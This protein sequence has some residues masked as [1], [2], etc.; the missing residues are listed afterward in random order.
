LRQ[1]WEPEELVECWTLL[2]ADR[3]LVGN[4]R[5][6]TRLGFALVLKFFEQEARFPR[7][8][9]EIP[10]AAVEYVASQVGVEQSEFAD[11][12]FSG[13]TITY[14][15]TQIRGAFGFREATR[16]DEDRLSGWLAE[17][18]C[19][20]ELDEE[21][22]RDA[23]LARCRAENIAPPGRAERNIGTA[24][25]AFERRFCER[26][27]S[28][29]SEDAIASLEELVADRADRARHAAG[30]P[31]SRNPWHRKRKATLIQSREKKR[32]RRQQVGYEPTVAGRFT[33]VGFREDR[34]G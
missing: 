25:S 18:V 8:G 2:E 28:R 32:V 27:V 12:D 19:P 33:D 11:Y 20:V 13:R 7:D 15:R 3:R 29:L 16:D 34:N 31:L 23:L 26:T 5:G 9:S 17:E 24:R 6:A 4:K 30:S 10:S 22:V 1:E 14:H 21:R